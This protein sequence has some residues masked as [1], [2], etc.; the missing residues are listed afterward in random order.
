M[1]PGPKNLIT[2]VDG[3]KVGH[4][5]DISLKSGVTVLTSDKALVSSVHVKGGA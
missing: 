2:D 3:L 5:Q 4:A 1:Q